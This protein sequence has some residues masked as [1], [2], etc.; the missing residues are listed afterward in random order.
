MDVV[1]HTI[2]ASEAFL[3]I[4]LSG[5]DLLGIYV[6]FVTSTDATFEQVYGQGADVLR[7]AFRSLFR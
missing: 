1:Q 5:K 2:Y 6:P 7:N 4:S 3:P